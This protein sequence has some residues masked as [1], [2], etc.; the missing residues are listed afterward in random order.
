ML[1]TFFNFKS[2]KLQE[3]YFIISVQDVQLNAVS[4]KQQI[5]THIGTYQK[6]CPFSDHTLA[7]LENLRQKKKS[8]I[9]KRICQGTRYEIN[10]KKVNRQVGRGGSSL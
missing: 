5:C 3:Y 7:H 1:S 6:K 4:Q 9:I 8:M 2:R 10:L